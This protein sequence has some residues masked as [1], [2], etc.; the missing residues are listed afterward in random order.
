MDIRG[1]GGG[2]NRSSRWIAPHAPREI[3]FLD[4]THPVGPPHAYTVTSP[5]AP[6]LSGEILPGYPCVP[7]EPPL[8]VEGHS[9]RTHPPLVIHVP[10]THD[11]APGSTT[12]PP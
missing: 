8:P 9:E 7:V 11:V 3:A 5:R 12:S 10:E 4:P 6:A 1:W 2:E